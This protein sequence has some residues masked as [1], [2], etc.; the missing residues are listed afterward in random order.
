MAAEEEVSLPMARD[1]AI[2]SLS[3]ALGDGD[4]V[5]DLGSP[6]SGDV[7]VN[8]APDRPPGSQMLLQLLR[9]NTA[10]LHEQGLV[11]RLV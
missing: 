8:A 11:D 2:L 9:Q 3:G 5:L 10:G 4:R 6:L 7:V 1:R